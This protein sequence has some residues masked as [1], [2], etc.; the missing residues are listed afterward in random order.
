MIRVK[1]RGDRKAL[2]PFLVEIRNIKN[3]YDFSQHAI[4]VLYLVIAVVL[5]VFG[6]IYFF[7]PRL[8]LIE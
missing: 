6:W 4:G 2:C 7:E 1:S 5:A 8:V 3:T